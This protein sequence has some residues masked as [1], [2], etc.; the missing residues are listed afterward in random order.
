MSDDPRGDVAV[1]PHADELSSK[2]PARGGTKS[3][4]IVT[5]LIFLFAVL[6]YAVLLALAAIGVLQAGAFV[7]QGTAQVGIYLVAPAFYLPIVVFAAAFFALVFLVNR[8]WQSK[9]VAGG[10]VIAII[11]YFS[12]I[13]G[14]LLTV[15]AWTLSSMQFDAFLVQVATSPLILAAAIVARE[16]PV[17]FGAWIRARDRPKRETTDA[18][19]DDD[20][21]AREAHK[22]EDERARDARSEPS[23]SPSATTPITYD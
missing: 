13:G 22:D 14:A 16:I 10:F 12:A 19:H 4:L 8:T 2:K 17:W 11:V 5:G 7:N 23:L 6:S 1:E 9:Y 15:S 3:P 20:A 18:A 21:H